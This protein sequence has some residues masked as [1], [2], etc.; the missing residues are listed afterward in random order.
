MAVNG[1]RAHFEGRVF[2][3]IGVLILVALAVGSILGGGAT[4]ILP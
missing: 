4:A 2:K 3:G 1:A